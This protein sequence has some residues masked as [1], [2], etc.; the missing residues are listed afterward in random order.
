MGMI[1]GLLLK[2]QLQLRKE[3]TKR[4]MG[5]LT[6]SVL[7]GLRD[8]RGRTIVVVLSTSGKTTG[9]PSLFDDILTESALGFL[10]CYSLQIV[11]RYKEKNDTK[12][13]A[14]W[15]QLQIQTF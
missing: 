8:H 9:L 6:Y 7:L 12:L 1:L 4:L 5:G 2:N 14:L 11:A 10:P 3:K 15:Y 13:I